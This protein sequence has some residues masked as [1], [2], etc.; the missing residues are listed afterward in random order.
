MAF[1]TFLRSTAKLF[2]NAEEKYG[3]IFH[4]LYFFLHRFH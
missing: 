2:M 4:S 3:Q 1:E